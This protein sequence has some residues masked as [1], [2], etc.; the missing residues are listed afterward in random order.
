MHRQGRLPFAPPSVAS[1]PQPTQP[2]PS[3]LGPV[4]KLQMIEMIVKASS[5]ISDEGTRETL[6]CLVWLVLADLGGAPANVR[7]A[8]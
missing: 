7:R 2:D 8:A 4:T 1:V 5:H 3:T 6:L